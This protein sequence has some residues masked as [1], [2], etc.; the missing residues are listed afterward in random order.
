MS[1]VERLLAAFASGRFVRPSADEPNLL[2]LVAAVGSAAGVPGPVPP[3][4]AAEIAGRLAGAE[5]IV[6]V[7]ADGLGVHFVDDLPPD[8]WLRRHFVQSLLAPFPS[9]TAVSITSVATGRWLCDHATPGWWSYI[10][11][12]D[13]IVEPLPY[14]R[15]SDERPLEELG[16][17]PERVFP[18]PSVVPRMRFA[19]QLV[20][21]ASIADSTYSRYIGGGSARAGY[22]SL[23][24]AVEHIAA[25]VEAAEGPTYTYWYVSRVDTL[26]HELGT[27]HERT[28]GAV[29]ELDE[30]LAALAARLAR[31]AAPTRLIVTADHGHLDIPDGGRHMLAADDPLLDMLRFH[32]TGDVRAVYFHLRDDADARTHT[33]FRAQFA[34]RCG[35]RWVLLTTDEVD[36]LRLMGPN[37]LSTETRRRIG[38]Y[39]AIALSAEVMRFAGPR[40]GERFLR[41][42]SQHSGL[43]PDEMTIPLVIGGA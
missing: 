32:P 1:D 23:A 42:Q 13:M 7:L 29:R 37:A 26:A 24:D 39:T 22:E 38:N 5:H 15:L 18:I 27:A 11:A 19:P 20:L 16:V 34:E 8:A 25:R 9:T 10:P 17:L 43:S 21:P 12:Y 14:H 41:Q 36:A 6:F 31:V 33:T 28:T 40:G 30:R 3:G 2:D 35:E 4:H